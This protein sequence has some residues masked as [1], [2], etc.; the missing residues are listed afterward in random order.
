M[1]LKLRDWIPF[2]KIDWGALSY[3]PNAIHILEKNLDKVNW[4]YLSENPNAIHLLEKNI[5]KIYWRELS[6]NPNAIHL[7]EQNIDKLNW[8][9]LSGN[10]SIFEYDYDA[11]TER[12]FVEEL[13]QHLYHP[14]RLVRQR[15]VFGYDIGEDE[16]M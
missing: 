12:P 3:N 6:G 7:L 16:Y 8:Y 14:D 4:C 9:W 15:E 2:D 10:P 13:M 1:T 5:D 11:M